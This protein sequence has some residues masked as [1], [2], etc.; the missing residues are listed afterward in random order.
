M[1]A[2]RFGEP[3]RVAF[4]GDEGADGSHALHA[5]APAVL[6]R[7]FDFRPAAGHDAA[8]LEAALDA[9]AP[10]VVVTFLP[11]GA[12]LA[13]HGAGDAARLITPDPAAAAWRTMPLPVDD[14]LS[15]SVR[16]AP[17]PPR[18]LFVGESSA[19]RER[20]LVGAKHEYDLVHYAHGLNG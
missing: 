15:A 1:G 5:P 11:G 6:P 8:E 3:A 7:F 12:T 9:W 4:V 18:A 2:P 19:H 14:R 17:G 20:F 16:R 13:P 10:H